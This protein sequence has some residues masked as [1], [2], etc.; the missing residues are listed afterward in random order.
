MFEEKTQ[1]KDCRIKTNEIVISP[2]NKVLE[3]F[4]PFKYKLIGSPK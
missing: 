4:S 3:D 1:K 2:P